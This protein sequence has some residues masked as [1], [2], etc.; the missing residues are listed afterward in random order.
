MNSW[1]AGSEVGTGNS[2]AAVSANDRVFLDRGLPLLLLLVLVF[3]TIVVGESW[4]A[5]HTAP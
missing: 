3:V 5:R 4:G 1:D 2:R